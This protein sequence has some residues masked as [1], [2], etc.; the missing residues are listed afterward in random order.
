MNTTI[1]SKCEK[2][3][4]DLTND[5]VLVNTAIPFKKRVKDRLKFESE[6][7]WYVLCSLMDVLSDTEL[8]KGNFLKYSLS[9]PTKILDYG[10]QYLRLYGIV[11]AIYLQKSA[12]SE[13]IQI[14]KF[15]GKKDIDKKLNA[16]KIIK[17]RHI[18]GAHTINY[19][20]NGKK[21]PHQFQRAMVVN[22]I[23]TSDSLGNFKDYDLKTLIQEFTSYAE[24]I[25]IDLC[26]KYINTVLKNGGQKKV[27]YLAILDVLKAQKAGH[28]VIDI[29]GGDESFVIRI[30]K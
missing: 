24:Q 23:T 12:I 29:P 14:I 8:A 20:D 30:T 28:I 2:L 27:K 26:E 25:L 4:R 22:N 3:I 17:F 15:K 16:L 13:F 11:N 1:I 5:V 9:G 6:Q 19:N 21:N 18:I 10:E 7:D